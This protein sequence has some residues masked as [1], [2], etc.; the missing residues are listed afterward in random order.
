[1]VAVLVTDSDPRSMVVSVPQLVAAVPPPQGVPGAVPATYRVLPEIIPIVAAV[2]GM[3]LVI[4]RV[5]ISTTLT[6]AAV[7]PHSGPQLRMYAVVS[8]ALKTA[9]TG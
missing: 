9:Q 4:V 1:M 3:T 8:S 5:S 2:T 6:L 7:P